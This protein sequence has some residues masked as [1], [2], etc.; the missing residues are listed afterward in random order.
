MS[1]TSLFE[2]WVYTGFNFIL[3]LPI[4]FYG[5]L[6]RDLTEEFQLKYPQVRVLY[7]LIFIHPDH[8]H[9]FDLN[10]YMSVC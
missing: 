8:F 7:V 1:G 5:F 2:S 4:I 9:M 10:V 3:G 6:D